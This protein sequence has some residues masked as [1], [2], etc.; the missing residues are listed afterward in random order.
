MKDS[1]CILVSGGLDSCVLAA[2]LA[3][4]YRQVYPVFVR[5]GLR[6][7]ATELRALRR[8][9]KAARLPTPVVLDLP[10]RDL[11]RGHWSVTG[12]AP[13]AAESA[14][15]AVF[16]PGR[17]L[18][19]LSKTAVFCQLHGIGPLAV[20]SLAG[21]PF[22]DATPAFFRAF[23]R[24]AGVR[25]IA[26]YRQLSKPQVIRRG[27]GLPLHLTF[28]CLAP[29]RGQH[30]GACNKCAERRAAFTRAGV[31]DGTRYAAA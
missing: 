10:M 6:W 26:P 23:S 28:S 5:Q 25:V 21:N 11:Y 15:E 8:F 3:R 30:C 2:E 24:L 4:R 1:V 16:L 17:N 7:E 19:L 31:A 29:H 22:S 12:K 9:L 27:R 14:D 20:G 18:L 13:P